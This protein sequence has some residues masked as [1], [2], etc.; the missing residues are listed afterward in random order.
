MRNRSDTID[1]SISSS[2][3]THPISTGMPDSAME[4]SVNISVTIVWSQIYG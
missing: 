4:Q 2:P 1:L 3:V